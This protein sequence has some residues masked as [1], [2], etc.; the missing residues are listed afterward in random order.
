M[1]FIWIALA[2]AMVYALIGIY[3]LHARNVEDDRPM[4]I[5]P[6]NP[7]LRSQKHDDGT[8]LQVGI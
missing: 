3:L 7:K 5:A 8:R 4:K 6:S 1:K 2:I